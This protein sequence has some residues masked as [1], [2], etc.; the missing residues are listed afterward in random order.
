M[1]LLELIYMIFLSHLCELNLELHGAIVVDQNNTDR[2]N[3]VFRWLTTYCVLCIVCV[4][5][6]PAK[7]IKP[8][9]DWLID[10]I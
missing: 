7:E 4:L 3:I 6:T 8:T 1:S 5:A 10:T 9:V 2:I